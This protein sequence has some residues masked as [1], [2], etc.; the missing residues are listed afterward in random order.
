MASITDLKFAALQGLG[1]EGAM[2]DLEK[3]FWQSLANG[4]YVQAELDPAASGT[5][6]WATI[7]AA[8][9][10]AAAYEL[11]SGAKYFVYVPPGEYTVDATAS[12]YTGALRLWAVPGTVK[13]NVAV[14]DIAIYV[15][16]LGSAAGP[17]TISAIADAV[18]PDVSGTDANA[19]THRLTCNTV[20]EA[21]NFQRGDSIFFGSTDARTYYTNN[22]ISYPVGSVNYLAEPGVVESINTTS[23]YI[24]LTGH[25]KLW[26]LFTAGMY[27]YRL[28][29]VDG[30]EI[31]GIDFDTLT[32]PV[33]EL[34][35]VGAGVG[36]IEIRGCTKAIIKHCTIH[37]S[38]HAAISLYASNRCVVQN[39]RVLYAP[40]NGSTSF[41]YGVTVQGACYGCWVDSNYFEAC[42]HGYTGDG[43]STTAA[44][45][46]GLWYNYGDQR[47]TIVSN[48]FAVGITGSAFDTHE[49]SIDTIF[50]NNVAIDSHRPSHGT[51]GNQATL[52]SGSSNPAAYQIRGRD[53][54]IIGGYTTGSQMGVVIMSPGIQ[55]EPI[56][57]EGSSGEAKPGVITV[58]DLVLDGTNFNNTGS[59][60]VDVWG[61]A[62]ITAA[63]QVCVD[64][65]DLNIKRFARGINIRAGTLNRIMFVN[66]IVRSYDVG[67]TI[68]GNGNYSFFGT[69]FDSLQ[70]RTSE[71][72]MEV[73]TNSTCVLT[74]V[75]TVHRPNATST[76]LT[77]A[78]G[79]NMTLRHCNVVNANSAVTLTMTGGAG[80][81]TKTALVALT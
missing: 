47:A 4:P 24:Y 8:A 56:T 46:S 21:A 6:N 52:V 53:D 73:G 57:G 80:T 59:Y 78:A 28:S 81:V 35:T 70:R 15:N 9:D 54:S 64:F 23:G 14:G 12:P 50:M 61:N 31:Y 18:H 39:N 13:F 17:Y 58:T 32:D 43:Y 26:S 3:Q 44:F 41:G 68:N 55:H 19:S 29:R 16:H 11:L 27:A 79:V 77:A 42:R 71:L 30:P 72:E 34:G 76:M 51:A 74:L 1:Y 36:M 75:N 40:A 10:Q 2:P 38:Y 69:V 7:T 33:T 22:V 48:N 62:S 45:N 49:P 65:V 37:R 60:A 66:G 63:N 25:L 5:T 67:L 20:G